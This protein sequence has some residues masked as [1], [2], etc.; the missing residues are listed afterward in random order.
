MKKNLLL[1]PI[2]LISFFSCREST[3]QQPNVPTINTSLDSAFQN[4]IDTILQNHPQSK[5]IMVHVEAPNQRISWSGAVGWA[6]STKL[7]PIQVN[8]TGSIASNTKQ[9]VSTAILRLVE[10]GKLKLD[11]SI[12]ELLST[13]TKALFENDGYDLKAITV[14]HLMSHTSG[15]FD[16]VNAP[17]FFE[18]VKSEPAHRYTQA[19]QLS[20]AV[21]HGS[22][23]GAPGDLFSYSD[24]NYSLLTDIIAT[25]TQKPFYTAIR[26]L[27]DYEKLG[28]DNTYWWRFEESPS[29]LPMIHQYIGAMNTDNHTIDLSFDLYGG[30]GI[31]ASA[32]DLAVFSQSLFDHKILK[33]STTLDL[34]YTQMPIKNG[35][36]PN[37]RLGLQVGDVNGLRTYGHGGFWATVVQYIPELDASIAVMISERDTRILRVNALSGL[38]DVLQKEK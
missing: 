16:Y 5:G 32:R 23:L 21:T 28:L 33:D 25:A 17:I 31:I 26:E 12:G 36:D 18:R 37:Y 22:P 13:E 24:T 2:V 14:A 30:G 3:P 4:V 11:Q 19:E 35:E 38:V 15:I 9:Y 29:E 1:I 6:D 8:Q 7:V 27:I 20:L 34:M 10:K